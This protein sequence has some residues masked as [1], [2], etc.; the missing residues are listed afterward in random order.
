MLHRF[1]VGVLPGLARRGEV[2]RWESS[3]SSLLDELGVRKA[4]NRNRAGI[5]VD[6]L[7]KV[8]TT[9]TTC[10]LDVTLARFPCTP[11]AIINTK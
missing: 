9:D 8:I 7:S 4:E 10:Q 2:S 11:P 6:I 5:R 1:L 3:P